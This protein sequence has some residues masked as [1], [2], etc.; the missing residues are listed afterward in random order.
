MNEHRAC[1]RRGLA[2]VCA[3]NRGCAWHP[4]PPCPV[5]TVAQLL[6]ATGGRLSHRTEAALCGAGSPQQARV[7][8]Q[9]QPAWLDACLQARGPQGLGLSA[10]LQPGKGYP[11]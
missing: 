6:L 11:A 2:S 8:G 7:Q 3:V 9:P 5:L 4:Q 10:R 1:V